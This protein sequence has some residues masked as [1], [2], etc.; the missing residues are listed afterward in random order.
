MNFSLNP[1]EL[2]GA[3]LAHPLT[4]APDATVQEA[5]ALMGGLQ[6]QCQTNGEEDDHISTRSSCV[7]IVIAEGRVRGILT[8]RDVVRLSAQECPLDRLPVAEVMTEPVITRRESDITD[9]FA[10]IELFK[11]HHIRHLP[12]V[13]DGDRL[14]GLITHES[15]RQ[16][17]RPIDL[18]RLR[19]VREVMTEQV[20]TADPDHSMLE[21]A[22]LMTTHR[23]SCIVITLPGGTPDAPF[24]RAVGLITERD[25]VQLQALGL[26]LTATTARMVMSSPVFTIAP[27][28]SLWTVQEMMAQHLIRRVIVAGEQGELLGI[29]TQTSML[30]AF[31]PLEL[32]NLAQVLEK[33][34]M[35]LEAERISLLE[36]RAAELEVREARYRALMEGASDAILLATPEGY[37]IEANTAAEE[38]FGYSR[39]ALTQLHYS[40]LYPPEELQRITQAFK[41]VISQQHRTILNARILHAN[42]HQ[43]PVDLSGTII[44]VGDN[45]IVQG[46]FRDIT[47]RQQAEA[48][49]AKVSQR[50]SI[51]LSS[52]SIGCWELNIPQNRITWDERM[53]SLYG[54]EAE[55]QAMI[56]YE[57]WANGLHPEDRPQTEALLQQ[58]AVGEAEYNTEF[59]VIHP[60][61]SLHYIRAY[62]VLVRDAAGQPQSMIGVNLDVTHMRQ[63]QLEL[64]ASETRF[65][66]VF[67]SNVVGMMFTNFAG[68]ITDANDRFLAMLGYSREDLQ[69]GQ[70]NWAEITPPEYQQQ[71][72]EAI[73]HLLTYHSIEPFE[74]VYW[75]RDGHRVPV[76]LGVAMLSH[77]SESCVCVVVDISDRKR[78]ENA[79]EE[80]QLRLQL[81][82]ESSNTGLWDWDV[83]TGELWFNKQW[84]GMLGYGEDELANEF[85]AWESRIHPD[86]LAH[87]YKDVEEHIA[88]K[89]EVYRNEHRLRT[90]DGSYRWILAQ[91]RIVERD[92]M[93]KA[94]RFL[95]THTDISDRKHSE[96]ER[97]K[98]VQELESFKFAL[99]QSAIVLST[100]IKGS[101]L[102]V[103]E[104]FE[105]ISGYSY[106]KILGK[107]PHIVNSGYHPQPFFAQMWKTI[108]A[109]RVWR[110]EICNRAKNGDIYWVDSTIIPFLNPQGEPTRFLS[111][112]FD[113]TTRKQVEL[114]IAQQL[115]QQTTLEFILGQIRQS[116]D[117]P[118]ILAIATQQVQ[119][120]L[121]GDRVIVF[122]VGNDGHSAIVAEAVAADL[123]SLKAIHWDAEIWPQEILAHYGQGQ[124]RIVPDVMDDIETDG[125]LAYCQL[126]RI[127][128]KIVA[129]ILQE[130]HCGEDHRW[131]GPRSNKL[132]GVLVVHAC[133]QQRVWRES[134]AQLLQQVANQLAI[135]IQQSHLFE[136]L[137]Q[138][139]G[140]RQEAEEQLTQRNQEL[141]RAT[142]LK[143]EFLANM[144][145]ELRTPL[146]AILGMTEGLEEGVFGPVNERQIKALNTIESSGSHLLALIN[147]ILDVAKIE[148]GQ[149][150]LECAPTAIAPLC[151]S[152]ITF[153][154]QQALKKRIQLAVNLPLNLP[155]IWL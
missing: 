51:A 17:T 146:N 76:L 37:I 90:K 149:V 117:L 94:L 29:I 20:L 62:G 95:G 72:I 147:D 22:R 118:E 86:D 121:Q 73:Y 9:L 7:V 107:S 79:L 74:K 16:Q 52:G 112:Q 6:I 141:I 150:E 34:V 97:Q 33:K 53:Y 115:R 104:R 114:D 78:Y 23:V 69:S 21:I 134:E 31:N 58:A 65:R 80:S 152:S 19:S 50:L 142:R 84:K 98:L 64:Q 30:K 3:I 60:D 140:E 101:I 28:A 93:G 116:L 135:A 68:E 106:G 36:S 24:Q 120:L 83:P 35:H 40:Q 85:S 133:H 26:K 32:Y 130:L 138:E 125:L 132:W 144:S 42:G 57:V 110:D 129:P 8:E 25:L 12:I 154:K 82:L 56:P 126:G 136:Q 75:H 27:E 143:D 92:E 38:L 151:Q 66:R 61:G 148:S 153:I 108:L 96:L 128:S 109:G 124:P 100:D 88:G 39:Q 127:Q 123:P 49:L 99:D 137:H 87:T 139:L 91:G 41:K 71:D 45:T 59:R 43:I 14:I 54:V 113:I 63:A 81:A 131:I 155:D 2:K 48:E 111:V 44:P 47:A 103:N 55:G 67:E 77:D 145:H 15:L 70:L 89:T 1:A 122:Q 10:A 13:D 46:I 11:H 5:I 4:L 18:L 102:Y 119:E 105:S